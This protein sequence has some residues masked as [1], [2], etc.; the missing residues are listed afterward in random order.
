[1]DP[2]AERR[3]DR[4]MITLRA[5]DGHWHRFVLTPEEAHNTGLKM[6]ALA[7]GEN[8]PRQCKQGA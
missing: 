8:T 6:I 5:P 3:G 4:I 1:M 2:I 7:A